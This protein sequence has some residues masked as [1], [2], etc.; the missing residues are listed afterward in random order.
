MGSCFN[1]IRYLSFY[2]LQVHIRHFYSMTLIKAKCFPI[3]ILHADMFMSRC[4]KNYNFLMKISNVLHLHIPTFMSTIRSPKYMADVYNKSACLVKIHLHRLFFIL[5]YY[6]DVMFSCIAHLLARQV[7]LVI[8]YDVHNVELPPTF[9][10]S[11]ILLSV[12]KLTN[13]P[14]SVV[15]LSPFT[16]CCCSNCISHSLVRALALLSAN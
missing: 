6:L 14:F 12:I 2:H 16:L 10:C 3:S 5:Q 7:A 4:E 15:I 1:Y 8:Q 13:F 9:A 11:F